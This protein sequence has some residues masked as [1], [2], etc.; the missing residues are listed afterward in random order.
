MV[1]AKKEESVDGRQKFLEL[2]KLYAS[3]GISKEEFLKKKE[4][5]S[6]QSSE[7][8]ESSKESNYFGENTMKKELEGIVRLD[9]SSWLNRELL[10]SIVSKIRV[11]PGQR[12]EI[13]WKCEDWVGRCG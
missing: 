2:Y 8:V 13:V 9:D 1:D 5:A 3:D 10:H 6:K 4:M 7:V 12:V 11:F